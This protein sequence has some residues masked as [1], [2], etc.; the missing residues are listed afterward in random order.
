MANFDIS[1]LKSESEVIEAIVN[2]RISATEANTRLAELK[3]E[4][5]AAVQSSPKALSCKVSVAGCVSVYGLQSQYPVSLF[6]EQ[7]TRLA[8]FIPTIQEFAK[9]NAAKLK[10]NSDVH[11]ILKAEAKNLAQSEGISEADALA[12]LRKLQT[13]AA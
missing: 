2:K 7:W 5:V 1:T 12:K 3:A 6:P 10:A 8:A 11:R 13:A 9:A 4:A